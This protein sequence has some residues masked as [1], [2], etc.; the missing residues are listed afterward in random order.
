MTR[1]VILYETKIR[2]HFHV[3]LVI[4]RQG[5]W[6]LMAQCKTAVSPLLMCWRYC[7]LALNHLYMTEVQ[8]KNCT[9][10]EFVHSLG[11]LSGL[12]GLTVSMGRICDG[13]SSAQESSA[14]L[15]W[16][17]SLCPV[18]VLL[19]T[20]FCETLA[21][22]SDME[23]NVSASLEWLLRLRFRF[24]W[25]FRWSCFLSTMLSTSMLLSDMM[26]SGSRDCLRGNGERRP[27]SW[28]SS[29]DIDLTRKIKLCIKS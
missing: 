14:P 20:K 9:F 25:L 5:I 12:A 21:S 11:G 28:L 7:S 26:M 3:I 13:G 18:I 22:S 23:S 6:I 24:C 19:R 8:E 17:S 10:I 16:P 15:L 4:E 27:L 29:R 2:H 1:G